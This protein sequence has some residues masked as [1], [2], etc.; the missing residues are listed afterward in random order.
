MDQRLRRKLFFGKDPYRAGEPEDFLRAVRE[1]AQYHETHCPAYADILR[2][3]GFDPAEIKT[4]EDLAKLPPITTLYLKRNTVLS[5]PRR[6]AFLR[7]TSS[8]TTGDLR[9]RMALD[10][11]SLHF[12]LKTARRLFRYHGVISARPVHYILLNARPGHGNKAGAAKTTFA[13]SHLAPALSRTYAIKYSDGN[14]FADIERVRKA[15]M[16]HA[17]GRTPVRFVGFPPYMAFLLKNLKEN[18]IRLQLDPRSM[19]I[20]GGGWKEYT[21]EAIDMK[22]M[23]ALAEEVL[24]LSADRILDFYS[25]VEHPQ[26]Y[27]RCPAGNFHIPV[28]SRVIIRDPDTLEPLPDWQRGLL[29][30]VSPMVTSMPILSLLTDDLALKGEK[31]SCG[32]PGPWFALLGRAGAGNVKTCTAQATMLLGE[33]YEFDTWDDL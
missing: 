23:A 15:L 16:K 13:V 10:L 1:C 26:G 14:P 25:A 32:Q 11:R 3:S 27:A 19:V 7:F 17:K 20:L 33:D 2:R 18:G 24:G 22:T 12:C 30:F 29:N 31:C 21:G 6:R 28:Y 5:V 8:G 4:E 9:S